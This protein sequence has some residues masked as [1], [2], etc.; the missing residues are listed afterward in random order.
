MHKD[1]WPYF[2][3]YVPLAEDDPS[4]YPLVTASA[5]ASNEY[6]TRSRPSTST[7]RKPKTPTLAERQVTAL[8]AVAKSTQESDMLRNAIM[9]K[10][11]LS[12]FTETSTKT[13]D[14]SEDEADSLWD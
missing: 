1:A 10:Y 11:K 9:N 6:A 14:L 2:N 7:Y 3:D 4:I 12:V 5:G 8:E 13:E